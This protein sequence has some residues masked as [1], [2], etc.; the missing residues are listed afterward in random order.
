MGYYLADLHSDFLEF[1]KKQSFLQFSYEKDFVCF[2]QRVSLTGDE[3]KLI[4]YLPLVKMKRE[5]EG[6]DDL[7]AQ[8]GTVRVDLFAATKMSLQDL[9][10]IFEW[11][12]VEQLLQAKGCTT[13]EIQ[14]VLAEVGKLNSLTFLRETFLNIK[15]MNNTRRRDGLDMALKI[16]I[17]SLEQKENSQL[18]KV[19]GQL[20]R[21][22]QLL[23]AMIHGAAL[24]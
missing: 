12:R 11:Q 16:Q 13:D 3:I 22:R 24:G 17:D 15:R 4:E 19:E 21:Q 9:V 7:F 14:R 6:C 8:V 20:S 23:N 5:R 10:A 1:L 2:E 18:R